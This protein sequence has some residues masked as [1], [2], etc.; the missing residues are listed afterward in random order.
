MQLPLASVPA[1]PAS[2]ASRIA[3]ASDLHP[4]LRRAVAV[5]L[6]AE[7]AALSDDIGLAADWRALGRLLRSISVELMSLR[8]GSVEDF[9]RGLAFSALADDAH[10]RS[11]MMRLRVERAAIRR[12]R[13]VPRVIDAVCR[14]VA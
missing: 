14:E 6:R 11:V 13:R 5:Q 3:A 10:N 7:M 12:G 8:H 4:I 1:R 9:D 2:L